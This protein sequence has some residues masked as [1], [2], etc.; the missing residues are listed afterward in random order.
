MI[1]ASSVRI[2]FLT[3]VACALLVRG[4]AGQIPYEVFNDSTQVASIDFSFPEGRTLEVSQLE[5]A[6]ALTQPGALAGLRRALSFIPGVPDVGAHPFDPVDL[7][8]DVVRLREA[9]AGFI[10]TRVWY[11]VEYDEEENEVDVRFFIDEGRPISV[12]AVEFATA[13]GA[14]VMQ[15][16][17]APLAPEWADFSTERAAEAVG[18]RYTEELRA[19]LSFDVLAWWMN[20]GWAFAH[21]SVE[22]S[23]DSANAAADVNVRLDV[24]P[25]AHIG[26]IDVE[27]NRG[28]S[29]EVIRATLPFEVGDRFSDEQIAEGQRRLF[30]LDLFRLVLVDA[31]SDQPRDSTVEV[32]VRVEETEPR[33]LI[34]QLG[35]MSAGG[36]ITGSAEL[37]NRNF[38]GGA[39]TLSVSSTFQTGELALVGFPEREYQLAVSYTRPF[40]AVPGLSVS[41]GPY[42][43]YQNNLVDRSWEAGLESTLLYELGDARFVTL[44]HRLSSRRI[45]DYRFGSRSSID[46]LTLLRLLGDDAVD[47]LG[48]RVDRSVFTLSGTIGRF[49]PTAPTRALQVRPVLQVTA[50]PILN[51]I[52]FALVDFPVTAYLPLGRNLA[53]TASAR[54]GRVFPFGK[55][56]RVG[57]D[58]A[59]LRGIQ[60]REVM[61]TAGGT[62][63]VRGWGNGLLGPKT[64]DLLFEAD[65]D[66]VSISS[67]GYL[68]AGGTA[69]A[70]GSLELRLPF[71]GLSERWGTH[72]FLDG[73][74]VW[75]PDARFRTEAA[76]A[77]DDWFFGIGGGLGVNTIMGP[78]RLS[79][80]YKLNPSPLDVRDPDALLEAI[81]N[82]EPLS[83]VPAK[84]IRR[85]HIHVSLGQG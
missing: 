32:R 10:G 59:L 54:V 27:G 14:A 78:I 42:G 84:S 68:P 20:R 51:T 61:L 55:S 34:G 37:T 36:G 79:V 63:S 40:L 15:E 8:R 47:S 21:A 57:A 4:A 6:I 60:L 39:R 43:R 70:S 76:A 22:A 64:L 75:T 3:M 72:V 18:R 49:D 31:R 19:G 46:L 50:P 28:V 71:P 53:F 44:Q 66:E 67:G 73:G 38:L 16:L 81:L 69:R 23:V 85:F 13:N 1:S 30:A 82:E 65:G 33:L 48:S 29:D 11:E 26:S 45:L 56:T 7:Q 58:D 62:G 83:T 25:R 52:E 24:G 5:E 41:V 80:G 17:P 9:Y 77:D 2:A 35:Y 74:R 12:R